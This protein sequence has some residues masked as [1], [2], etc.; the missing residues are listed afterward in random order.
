MLPMLYA[1]VS[2]DT[3]TQRVMA[4]LSALLS[5]QFDFAKLFFLLTPCNISSIYK[6]E[7]W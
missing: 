2:F 1:H 6:F 4:S 3:L 7:D 5:L